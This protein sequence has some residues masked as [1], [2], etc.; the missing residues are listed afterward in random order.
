MSKTARYQTPIL[1]AYRQGKT[2]YQF[3]DQMVY[4]YCQWLH[5]GKPMDTAWFADRKPTT[6]TYMKNRGRSITPAFKRDCVLTIAAQIDDQ[7]EEG[8]SYPVG[9]RIS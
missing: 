3:A 1:K 8:M 9:N 5:A 4:L 6:A 2:Q 7:T